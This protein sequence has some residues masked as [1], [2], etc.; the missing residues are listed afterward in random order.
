MAQPKIDQKLNNMKKYE[1]TDPI[2]QDIT[3]A[4]AKLFIKEMIPLQSKFSCMER[5]GIPFE[6]KVSLSILTIK[7]IL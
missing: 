7:T 4:L 6:L 3:R 1:K 2:H 5:I